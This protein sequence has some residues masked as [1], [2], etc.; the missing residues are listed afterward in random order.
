MST[1]GIPIAGTEPSKD[2]K[3]YDRRSTAFA[4]Y[5]DIPA[6]SRCA[7]PRAS[8]APRNSATARPR[9]HDRLP[10]AAP[11]LLPHHAHLPQACPR[12]QAPHPQ[13]CPLPAG[14]KK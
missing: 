11:L 14:P 13:V 7:A 1:T 8:S 4:I 5:A 12:K 10:P 9:D 3:A 2:H 6:A